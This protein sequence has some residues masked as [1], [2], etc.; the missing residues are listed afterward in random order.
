MS[1]SQ[2]KR[3][4]AARL[5]LLITLAI[6]N[7]RRIGAPFTP[8]RRRSGELYALVAA[9]VGGARRAGVGRG[10]GCGNGCRWHGRWF[11]GGRRLVRGYRRGDDLTQG[12]YRRFDDLSG[13][14][15][16][17]IIKKTIKL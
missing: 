3:R 5:T 7:H 10:S 6:T 17:R 14:N 2:I 9:E 16:L 12:G 1:Y 13:G 4:S 15:E 11:G 8:T